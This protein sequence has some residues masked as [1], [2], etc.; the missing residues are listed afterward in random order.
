MI[1]AAATSKFRFKEQMALTVYLCQRELA[2]RYAGS[3]LGV[4]WAVIF[5]ILQITI[6][7]AVLHFGLR[8][9]PDG[10]ESLL[11]LLVAG[12]LPWFA[13]NDALNAMTNAITGNASLVKHLAIPSALLPIAS[14]LAAGVVHSVMIGLSI[15]ML[16]L[17]GATPGF[18]VMWLPY[19]T[20]CLAVFACATGVLLALA[21]TVFRDISHAVGPVLGLW[22]WATPILWPAERLPASLHW[23]VQFNPLSYVVAGYRAALL[24]ANAQS[25][26]YKNTLWFWA[27]TAIVG[28]C[29]WL[30]FRLFQRDL[31]D[32]V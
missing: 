21:N 3:V 20:L 1:T 17:L 27:I 15:L 6:Y 7:A 24:G 28:L 4:L 12:M 10:G 9:Q 13:F 26:D 8:F 18:S 25:I 22:F 30:C 19:F 5:P 11:A 14:L 16:F 32:L 29:A 23:I 31:A 2:S